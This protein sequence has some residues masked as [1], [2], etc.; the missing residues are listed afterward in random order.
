MAFE[1]ISRDVGLSDRVRQ[2]ILAKIGKLDKFL[3]DLPDNA[4]FLRV[5]LSRNQ[6]NPHW[7]DALLDLALPGNVLIG[8]ESASTPA[9]AVHLAVINLERQLDQRKERLKPYI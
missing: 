6:K 2:E 4:F 7:T 8:S 1:L 9:H 5:V 3:T